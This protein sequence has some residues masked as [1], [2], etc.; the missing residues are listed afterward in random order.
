[1]KV[2]LFTGHD[3]D[4]GTPKMKEI[5][6]KHKGVR[7]RVGEI[8]EY[9]DNNSLMFL[10]LNDECMKIAK[11]K[12]EV[13][14]ETIITSESYP[15]KYYYKTNYNY[16]SSFSIVDVDTT[17]PWTIKEYDNAEYIKYLDEC[18]LADEELN[19]WENCNCV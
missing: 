16:I 14:N 12:M 8:I 15:E 19:Y 3:A 13:D 11:G 6:K 7:C 17:R 18:K 4:C 9:I 5:M 10:H 1:M 2:L